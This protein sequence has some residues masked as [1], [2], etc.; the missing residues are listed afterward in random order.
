MIYVLCPKPDAPSGGVWFLAR[1]VQL[2]NGLGIEA[3]LVK[4]EPFS[5]YWDAHPIS[6]S[7][8]IT[9]ASMLLGHTL[10][11][12]E[13][14][15]PTTLES[16][17]KILFVQNQTWMSK[18]LE[19][20][21]QHDQALVCSRYL[22]NYLKRHYPVEVIGKITPFLDPDVF[23][24]TPKQKDRTLVIARRNPYH[25]KMR[26]ALEEAGFPVTYV[27]SPLT[28]RQI[29]E[30]LADCEFYV[31]LNHPEGWPMACAEAMRAGTIVVGTT[32]GGGNDF[33]YDGETASVVQDPENGHYGDK[34]E[35]IRRIMD[36]MLYLRTHDEVRSRIWTQAH[37][38]VLR[39]T[40]Q[41][42]SQDLLKV[43]GN[44]SS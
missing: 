23:N 15:W 22:A 29:A 13:V 8:V 37:N 39:Y 44:V 41:A 32:G 20:Y 43:F 14:I 6:E 27:T 4:M 3:R 33:M 5:I 9:P 18:E 21:R 1:I 7:Q 30:K 28:Q 11:I 2:L 19:L 12:P 16:K 17:R 25:A 38:W 42:T 34:D 36:K 24:P 10:V 31:H 26:A 40:A 35:F